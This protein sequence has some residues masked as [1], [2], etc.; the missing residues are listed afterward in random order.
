MD[1]YQSKRLDE[2]F[3]EY[4]DIALGK[5]EQPHNMTNSERLKIY[6][7]SFHEVVG[8]NLIPD[9]NAPRED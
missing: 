8:P 9:E 1:P 3:M 6:R 7:D 5:F 4:L 2:L